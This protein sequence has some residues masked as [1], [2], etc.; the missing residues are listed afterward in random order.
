M[1]LKTADLI[2]KVGAKGARS[3]IAAIK[4][5]APRVALNV[6]DRAIQ[7][8]GGAGVSD[9]F[10]LARMYAHLRT[11]RIADGPDEVHV[12]T[13]ARQELGQVR[14]GLSRL[15]GARLSEP[16]ARRCG[17][18]RADQL[19]R[20]RRERAAGRARPAPPRSSVR[21]RATRGVDRRRRRAGRSAARRRRRSGPAPPRTSCC[22]SPG[23][24]L[25]RTRLTTTTGCTPGTAS[26]SSAE[27]AHQALQPDRVG[28]RRP[29]ARCRRRPGRRASPR[30]GA[31]RWCRRPAPRPARGR[32]RS[33]P[34]CTALSD[35]GSLEHHLEGRAGAARASGRPGRA[36]TAPRSGGDDRAGE[37]GEGRHVEGPGVGEP[38]GGGEAGR[39]VEQAEHLRDDA[40]VDVGVDEQ[41]RCRR[42]PRSSLARVTATVVRP[43]APV[44]PQTAT[45]RPAPVRRDSSGPSPGASGAGSAAA[46]VAGRDPLGRGRLADVGRPPRRPPPTAPPACCRRAARAGRRAGAGA[47][48][49]PRRRGRSSATTATPATA[50]RASAS[51]SSRRRSADSRTARARPVAAVAS[52][53]A[54]STHR[55]TTATP[56][57]PRSSAATSCG[58]PHGV[59]DGRQHRDG[60]QPVPSAPS[61]QV[62]EVGAGLG[63]RAAPAR[64]RA[65][66]APSRTRP[67]RPGRDAPAGRPGP[68]EPPTARSSRCR[69]VRHHDRRQHL[70]R[71]AQG[72]RAGAAGGAGV[73]AA[74]RGRRSRPGRARGVTHRSTR[75]S[76]RSDGG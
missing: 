16:S 22:G 49:R 63:R 9:D 15:S 40:A 50:S 75:W 45:T 47:A 20:E 73:A 51:R 17:R 3:E 41:C 67:R 44:G 8:H 31:A 37:R 19:G 61:G 59:R 70:L 26:R 57:S 65:G 42:A 21:P 18:R 2:D 66:R 35:A 11:L 72:Q 55:R 60:H 13:V 58:L 56:R 7:V 62:G 12:R 38:G 27:P 24:A 36:R 54:R 34:P 4:V 14:R 43:G 46:R 74:G 48:R 33:R 10:P 68:A 30:C 32:S 39:L 76:S 53:S 25:A 64:G 69:G 23:T 29:R 52:R 71:A 1:V 6:V 28:R 5:I